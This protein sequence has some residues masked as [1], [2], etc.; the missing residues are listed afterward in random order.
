ME[1]KLAK[2]KAAAA[3]GDWRLA[4]RIAAR[5]QDLGD[6][7]AEIKRGHEAFENARFYRQLGRDPD[8]LIDQGIAAL[9]AR[10]HL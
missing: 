8:A 9:K 10:Y 5:F 4:L 6:H 2:L 1:T 3:S 7:K